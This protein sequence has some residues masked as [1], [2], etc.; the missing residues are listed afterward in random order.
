MARGS[1]D[2]IEPKT[3]CP[4]DCGHYSLV[5]FNPLS[6]AIG[7]FALRGTITG[8]QSTCTTTAMQKEYNRVLRGLLFV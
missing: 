4:V 7:T 2:G 5:P 1:P 6:N 3:I 8:T